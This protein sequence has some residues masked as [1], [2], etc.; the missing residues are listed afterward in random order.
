MDSAPKCPLGMGGGHMS[1]R[2]PHSDAVR[3][4]WQQVGRAV[5]HGAGPRKPALKGMGMHRGRGQKGWPAALGGEGSDAGDTSEARELGCRAGCGQGR[6]ERLSMLT[7]PAVRKQSWWWDRSS[8][9]LS[10]PLERG[11]MKDVPTL[12]GSL[13]NI[14]S[15]HEHSSHLK[16]TIQ[17]HQCLIYR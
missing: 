15:S 4:P 6:C 16:S 12:R 13:T 1:W 5:I 8:N 9:E 14:R 2:V 10:W 11:V 17:R 3:L 7:G